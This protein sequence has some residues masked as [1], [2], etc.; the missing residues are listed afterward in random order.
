MVS[1]VLPAG[2]SS[3]RWNIPPIISAP[4]QLF[5]FSSS[6]RVRQMTPCT[7]RED[8]LAAKPPISHLLF[9]EQ[10]CHL[11]TYSSPCLC[12]HYYSLRQDVH[13]TFSVARGLGALPDTKHLT[14][15]STLMS[16]DATT[17]RPD[18]LPSVSDATL[19]CCFTCQIRV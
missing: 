1:A 4:V 6:F 8:V 14:F 13:P 10:L 11:L 12:Y 18:H 17:A 9:Q 19:D 5:I 15:A 16:E 7:W 3:A 2:D